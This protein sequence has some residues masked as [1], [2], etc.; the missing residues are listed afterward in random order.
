MYEYLRALKER[1][2]QTGKNTHLLQE[3]EDHRQALACCTDKQGRKELLR[4][5]DAQSTL[6]NEIALE[7][8]VAGFRL[9]R[10][11]DSELDMQEPYSYTK[12]QE[13]HACEL[14]RKE[15]EN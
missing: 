12:E 6:Q 3:I 8:F 7:S 1:F 4:L 15:E 9:A 10:G 5:L 14:L 2:S 13:R 11:I